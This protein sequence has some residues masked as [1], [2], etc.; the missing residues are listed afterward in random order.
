[1]A[2]RGQR[3]NINFDDKEPGN[4]PPVPFAG[5]GLL[6][7]IKE[8]TASPNPKPPSPPRVKNS[9]TGFPA[10]K[11]RTR[12]SGFKKTQKPSTEDAPLQPQANGSEGSQTQ[13]PHR[14]GLSRDGK[15]NGNDVRNGGIDPSIDKEN[16][17]RLANMSEEEIAAAREELMSGLSPSL[18]EKLLKQ[19]NVDD[20]AQDP[21]PE[22]PSAP[23]DPPK[24]E[25]NPSPPIS[26][27]RVTFSNPSPPITPPPASTHATPEP[28]HLNPDAPPIQP[29]PDL[30]PASNLLETP[31]IHFPTPKP[32]PSLDPSS[33]TFL[34]SL[35]STYFP[36]LPSDPSSL[37]W[38]SPPTPAER[39]AY[40]PDAPSLAP[41]TLRFDFRGRLLPPRLS[42]Q[43]PVSKGLH[44]HGHAPENAG[45]TIPELAMLGR[46]TVP[47]Q[48]CVAWQT[49]GRILFRLGRGDFGKEDEGD[50]GVGE[51]LCE[52]IWE[53]VE[54]E[55]AVEGLEAAA[56]KEG[57][58][59]S[60]WVVATEAVWLWRRGGGRRWKGR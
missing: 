10:H 27:K 24:S 33:P 30:Q 56:G 8:R 6:G 52:G 43:I 20:E 45:Y 18:I 53:V 17:E 47:P 25:P 14:E 42:A 40:T 12:S 55:K 39:A 23:Q 34:S 1:M 38:L 16:N 19:A 2:I 51:G 9:A 48:R 21:A 37:S 59:R 44:H 4:T 31:R 3:F 35:H 22:P 15:V 28:L 5:F 11:D 46:S 50:G 29:P 54:G 57:G 60:E 36:S 13:S 49:L 58:G 26:T 41:S 7:E 32:P